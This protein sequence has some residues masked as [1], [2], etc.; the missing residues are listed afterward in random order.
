M[1]KIGLGQKYLV[2]VSLGLIIYFLVLNKLKI[3]IS[4]N[5]YLFTE[6]LVLFIIFIFGLI[7]FGIHTY[8]LGNQD[9]FYYGLQALHL[10]NYG[11]SDVGDVKNYNLGQWALNDWVG[12]KIYLAQCFALIGRGP[13]YVL[14]PAYFLI[15]YCCISNTIYFIGEL[16]SKNFTNKQA[17]LGSLFVWCNPIV[18]HAINN[19]FL[20]Q[21]MEIAIFSGIGYLLVRNIIFNND[22]KNLILNSALSAAGLLVYTPFFILHIIGLYIGIVVSSK[23]WKIVIEYI[24]KNVFLTLLFS[25][26]VLSAM[27]TMALHVSGAIAG[28]PLPGFDALTVLFDQHNL[29]FLR[30]MH[31]WVWLLFIFFILCI[32]IFNRKIHKFK[33]ISIIII[34]NGL[35][36]I[37]L[38]TDGLNSYKFWK[39]YVSTTPI[40]YLIVAMFFLSLSNYSKKF[41]NKLKKYIEIFIIIILFSLSIYSS[42]NSWNGQYAFSSSGKISNLAGCIKRSSPGLIYLKVR[43]EIDANSLMMA[44]DQIKV[45]HGNN[46][47]NWPILEEGDEIILNVN[48]I[49]N[50]RNYKVICT[51]DDISYIKR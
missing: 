12:T 5:E 43:S 7:K 41:N 25:C 48:D 35:F 31:N 49:S 33:L 8:S 30:K 21:F 16:L 2:Y 39:G 18:L 22:I 38:A 32:I 47:L 24:V 27:L 44:L 15:I 11:F 46:K 10:N 45:Y 23:Q 3:A 17:L 28:W 20:A 40:I 36:L 19:Y 37:Y 50:Y 13:E 1:G 42:W 29:Y 51:S 4:T 34:F 6:V 14:W 26:L 9:I